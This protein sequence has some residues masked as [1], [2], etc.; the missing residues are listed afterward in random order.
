MRYIKSKTLFVFLLIL[1]VYSPITDNKIPNHIQT[2]ISDLRK[3]TRELKTHNIE[4]KQKNE[5]FLFILDRWFTITMSK[6]QFIDN[7]VF[8]I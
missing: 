2:D 3:I 8:Y 5:T 7:S 4:S 6:K 1:H